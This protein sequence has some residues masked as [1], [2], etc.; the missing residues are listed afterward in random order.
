MS[1]VDAY[2]VQILTYDP[3]STF[4]IFA[5]LILGAFMWGLYLGSR[6]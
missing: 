5:A 2:L 6:R 1:P 3:I 4:G